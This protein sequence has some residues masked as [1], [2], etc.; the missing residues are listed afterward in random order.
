MPV[1]VSAKNGYCEFRLT[2]EF[3]A[4]GDNVG[5]LGLLSLCVS[6]VLHFALEDLSIVLGAGKVLEGLDVVGL[7]IVVVVFSTVH[8]LALVINKEITSINSII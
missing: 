5:G 6:D 7:A 4:L 1:Q 3:E 2:V 8:S